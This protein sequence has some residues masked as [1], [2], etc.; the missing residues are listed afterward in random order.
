VVDAGGLR[1][2]IGN[3]DTAAFAGMRTRFRSRYPDFKTF[4]NAG[5]RFNAEERTYKDELRDAFNKAIL[6]KLDALDNHDLCVE[7]VALL[8]K[9]LPST[10]Q[11]QNLINVRWTVIPLLRMDEE[12]RKALGTSLRALLKAESGPEK[13]A[14]ALAKFVAVVARAMVERTS[15]AKIS[16]APDAA[17]LHGTLA[18][19]LQNPEGNIFFRRSVLDYVHQQL[20]GSSA[21][22]SGDVAID[23]LYALELS[24]KIRDALDQ[25]AK[26]GVRDLV[27]VQSFL[28]VA[29]SKSNDESHA[30]AKNMDHPLNLILYGPPGTGKTYETA[31]IAV[32]ICDGQAP[33][34]RDALM[35][36]YQQL[37]GK[38]RIE[39]I[40]F[41]QSYSYEDFVEGL[42]PETDNGGAGFRLEVVD[43]VLKK[44][45]ERATSKPAASPTRPLEGRKV[46]KMSLGQA[47]DP[48]DAY[49]FEECIAGGYVL[50]GWGGDHDYSDKRFEH[51]ESFKEHWKDVSGN[52][53]L[54]GNDPN[55]QMPFALRSSAETG[56]LILVSE[57]NRRI[58]AIAEITGGY[59]YVHRDQ[60]DYHHR[61][62]V[63]W[64][65]HG[66][67]SQPADR[68]YKRGLQQ[69]SIYRLADEDVNWPAISDVLGM[70]T[71]GD[72]PSTANYV[73]IIDEINRANVSKVFG[74][75]MTLLEPDK[76]G[77]ALNEV[78]VT[79]PYSQASFVL[80]SNLHI[81]G[82]MNTADRSIA[83]LDAALR[84]RFH[85]RD[86]PPRADVLSSN[87]EGVDLRA[88]LDGINARLEYLF[89][90][91]HLIGHAFLTEVS[92][93]SDLGIA[94]HQSIIPQLVEYF[95]E[96][97]EKV[98]CVLNESR[99]AG[100]FIVRTALPAPRSLEN[101]VREDRY[102]YALRW[103]PYPKEAFAQL[104]ER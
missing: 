34:D 45:A 95:H 46:F 37:T 26:W 81:V 25:D 67:P 44:A 38:G 97:W 86:V 50:L 2:M 62:P 101:A 20:L 41:H 55:V 17:R 65:W 56:D 89:D 75:L 74:E 13:K 33:S 72:V 39:F 58:R 35:E 8:R 9:A 94:F 69:Q 19:M 71:E 15:G 10:K 78:R 93:L 48:S 77:G 27:D 3:L 85:F 82:T 51:F 7:W 60:D 91:D 54:R 47:A 14:T 73:L 80:P 96:D 57:G 66:P 11:P 90:R 70:T 23:Y 12:G 88:V 5:E 29:F 52:P 22:R 21:P 100:T 32:E 61:R 104:A 40:T 63:K 42:R 36:R 4:S 28:W 59:E 31:Q 43:G 49:L 102:R 68:F 84:R 79:L 103:P 99:D 16:G 98:R 83:L 30:E 24:R 53:N 92:S 87:V 76:R 6:S 1:R 18:L 64:L